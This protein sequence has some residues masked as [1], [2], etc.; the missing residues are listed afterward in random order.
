LPPEVPGPFINNSMPESPVPAVRRHVLG[1]REE[2][3]CAAGGG[4]ARTLHDIGVGPGDAIL[5]KRAG[6]TAISVLN[7]LRAGVEVPRGVAAGRL[8]RLTPCVGEDVAAD[9]RLLPDCRR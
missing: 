6:P 5:L 9:S 2:G 8:P 3:G 7:N 4:E 1:A